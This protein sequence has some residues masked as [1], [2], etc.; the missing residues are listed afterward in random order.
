MDPSLANHNP[1]PS[2]AFINFKGFDSGFRIR[3]SNFIPSKTNYRVVTLSEFY[4][5][6][7]YSDTGHGEKFIKIERV[8]GA[9]PKE[10]FAR[11]NKKEAEVLWALSESPPL[12]EP[13]P[14]PVKVEVHASGPPPDLLVGQKGNKCALRK[15]NSKKNRQLARNLHTIY[16]SELIS[17][18]TR[19][20]PDVSIIN[21]R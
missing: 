20:Y 17:L 3:V 7:K 11:E 16:D 5:T 13:V 4:G 1:K 10:I 21:H 2:S 15:W 12:A 8:V 18:G 9:K 14:K 6:C 19:P